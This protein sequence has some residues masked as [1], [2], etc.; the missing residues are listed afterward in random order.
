MYDKIFVIV[1]IWTGFTVCLQWKTCLRVFLVQY[2]S[3]FVSDLLNYDVCFYAHRGIRCALYLSQEQVK[4]Y[5]TVFYLLQQ[6]AELGPL[7]H[8]SDM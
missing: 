2:P 5:Q 4:R 8:C 7:P 6:P 3:R 1:M